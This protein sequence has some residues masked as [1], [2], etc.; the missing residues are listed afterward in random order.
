MQYD[1]PSGSESAKPA[2]LTSWSV[3]LYI[4][5]KDLIYRWGKAGT[6]NAPVSGINQK[7]AKVARCEIL[8]LYP[9]GILCR[10]GGACLQNGWNGKL[11]GKAYQG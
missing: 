7:E 5:D 2:T 1:K 9:M 8:T 10:N 11:A 3:F 6:Q 4:T